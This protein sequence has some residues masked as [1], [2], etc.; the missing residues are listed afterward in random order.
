V[1]AALAVAPPRS[2]AGRETAPETF[3]RRRAGYTPLDHREVFYN[4]SRLTAGKT[5]LLC[6]LYVLQSTAGASRAAGED[7]PAESEP[8]STEEF[9]WFCGEKNL[10]TVQAALEDLCERKVLV[11][12]M[13][14]RGQYVY[15]AP[16]ASWEKLPSFLPPKKP[17]DSAES[18]DESGTSEEEEGDEM[19]NLQRRKLRLNSLGDQPL[20]LS[21]GRPSKAHPLEALIADKRQPIPIEKV[22]FDC[23]TPAHVDPVMYRGILRI[24]I[25]MGSH[26]TAGVRTHV[27][28]NGANRGRRF[29][30]ENCVERN[31]HAVNKE[32]SD[33]IATR[34][35]PMQAAISKRE[36]TNQLAL[37]REALNRW[38]RD[39]LG[40]V[41]DDIVRDCIACQGT[42]TDADVYAALKRRAHAIK[43]WGLVVVI[44][45]DVGRAAAKAAY[46]NKDIPRPG[47]EPEAIAARQRERELESLRN[48][49][50]FIEHDP[51]HPAARDAREVLEHADPALV[52]EARATL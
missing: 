38:L 26:D 49:I 32:L 12:K 5:Q 21:A 16:A 22:Q 15:A 19:A 20:E 44:H 46:V 40:P 1:S 3:K 31:G 10:R 41:D 47:E 48:G 52:A 11:R 51:D 35:A 2:K 33:A 45:A 50:R 37:K 17:V 30:A 29:N 25:R 23:D 42:A 28:Q 18:L 14:K 8:I 13:K 34:G 7:A 4:L 24:S 6:I 9:A 39:K 27:T 36:M 43:G